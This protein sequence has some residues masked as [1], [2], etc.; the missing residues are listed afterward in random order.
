MSFKLQPRQRLMTQ[1][2]GSSQ[3]LQLSGFHD[4]AIIRKSPED[5]ARNK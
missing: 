2:K 1:G 4:T 3:K 5:L